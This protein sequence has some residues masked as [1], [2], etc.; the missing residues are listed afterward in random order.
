MPPQP[1]IT[2]QTDNHGH[3]SLVTQAERPTSAVSSQQPTLLQRIA[4]GDESAVRACLAQYT[5]LVWSVARKFSPPADAEDAVQD[6]F[7]DL[8]RSAARFD[9]TVASEAA[10]VVM[11]ARRRL[12]D[13]IRRAARRPEVA[14]LPEW[15][16]PRDGLRGGGKS[17]AGAAEAAA[18]LAEEALIA[19]RA[20]EELSPEQRRVLQLAVNHGCTHAQIA[21][22]TGLPLGTV[23]THVRRGL[24]KVRDL[25]E[26]NGPASAGK[27]AAR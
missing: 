16:E 3:R 22:I 19:R 17:G 1:A 21:D 18:E 11:I 26:S 2:P 5:D 23:K 25:L 14:G 9:P 20:M 10:F 27:G 15:T 8:W 4:R 6:V 7:V 12:I 13:R 24:I